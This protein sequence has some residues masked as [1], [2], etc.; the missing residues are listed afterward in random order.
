MTDPHHAGNQERGAP[1]PT[2]FDPSFERLPGPVAGETAMA[3]PVLLLFDRDADRDWVADAA[4]ALAT[5]WHAA[6][7]RT[8]LADLCLE[9]PF[10]N[11]RIGL[12]NQEGV[13]DIFL[14]GASLARSARVVPGRGFHL[15]SAGTYTPDA[16][17]VLRSPRWDKIVAGFRDAN[18]AMLLF[19]PLDAPELG[20][21]GRFAGESILLGSPAAGEAAA[22]ALPGL[23]VRAWL[24]P[25]RGNPAPPVT[26]PPRAASP[27]SAPA[28]APAD[29]FPDPEPV[30]P[31]NAPAGSIPVPPPTSLPAD[32]AYALPAENAAPREI[33]VFEADRVAE[34]V[35]AKKRGV[36]PLLLIL[37]LIALL[38]AAAVLL[39]PRLGLALPFLGG[40][41][42]EPAAPVAKS[43]PARPVSGPPQPRGAALPYSV[44]VQNHQTPEAAEATAAEGARRFPEVQFFVFPE[45][46]QGLTY[47]RVMAGMAGD[48][49][50]VRALRDRL[51]AAKL[52]DPE[53]V[54]GPYDLIQSRPVTYAVG[55]FADAPQA[56]AR[57]AELAQK[58]I[59]SYVTPVPFSDGTER[60]TVYAGAYRDTAAAKAMGTMLQ[61]ARIPARVVQR[62][63]RPPA[64]PK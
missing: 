18:A 21:L 33:P 62:T 39:A 13:V 49:T 9:D 55:D 42:P 38:L 31:W 23:T 12:P 26:A 46:L 54:S 20:A 36:S 64:A 47:W 2:F 37:L 57:V 34:P 50:Q 35:A 60:W 6:G 14:Y 3:G 22:A 56:R 29:R 19:A 53:D 52:V 25:P 11:E 15:I 4:V 44:F 5:G 7:R 41:E 59:P 24:A 51:L 58:G 16:G 48:T 40:A 61:Q 10:L 8:V 30:M 32:P 28:A 17:E 43:A 63:G 1:A 45:A 27:V